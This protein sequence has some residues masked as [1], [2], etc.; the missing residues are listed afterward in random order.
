MNDQLESLF[1][2][3]EEGLLK[4]FSEL[5]FQALINKSGVVVLLSN[6][7]TFGIDFSPTDD[8][9]RNYLLSAWFRTIKQPTKL[10]NSTKGFIVESNDKFSVRE[11]SINKKNKEIKIEEILNWFKQNKQN[12]YKL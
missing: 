8:N 10:I 12:I 1:A 5:K 9:N 4:I 6:T 3:S 11:V 7:K 2:I